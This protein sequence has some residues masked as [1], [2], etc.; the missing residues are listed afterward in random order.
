MLARSTDGGRS[1]TEAQ[2]INDDPARPRHDQFFPTVAVGR[3]GAVHLL[4]LDRRDDAANN[5]Y[6]PYYAASTDGGATFAQ[7]PL[8]RTPSDPAI[9]FQGSLL[10]DYIALDTSSDGSKVYAAWVDTRNGDQDIY[11][12]A[13][14]AKAGP[15]SPPPAATRPAPAAVPSPQPLT[16]F[17]DAA[18]LRKWQRTDRPVLLGRASRPWVWGPVSFAAASE[19]YAQG[20][21]GTRAVQYFDKARMEI[22][23]P[24]VDLTSRYFVTNGLLVV[25]LVSG[26]VQTG[27]NEFEPA[28]APA[29]IPVAGDADSPDALTYASLAPVA[30][31]NGDNRAPDKAGQQVTA[32]LERSGA[33]R[34]DP[35]RAGS[36]RMVRYEPVLGHNIPS[37]FWDFMNQKGPVQLSSPNAGLSAGSEEEREEREAGGEA[38]EGSPTNITMQTIPIGQEQILDWEVDLGYPITEPYWTNVKIAGASKWVLVQAFQRRVLTYVA[39]NPPGWQ[40]EMGNVGRHYFDWRYNRAG[41]AT[42]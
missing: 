32:V 39:D 15:E 26:R 20:R 40:V 3:D 4:W 11:F 36:V 6:L 42:R 18:F 37:V 17:F 7:E 29:Q 13:F 19:A 12:A 9:G 41:T 5:L 25:E 22:N 28:R 27:N 23:D 14:G 30:S 8:S 38:A 33:T 24:G 31:L 10:G 2:R 21:G 1:W 35:A 34:D 16:G